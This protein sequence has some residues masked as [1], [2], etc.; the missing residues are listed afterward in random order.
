[1]ADAKQHGFGSGTQH[2]FL[3]IGFSSRF[4]ALKERQH[5]IILCPPTVPYPAIGVDVADRY[6]VGA[7]AAE[8]R[9]ARESIILRQHLSE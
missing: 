8:W 3:S 4:D 2:I 6:A 5:R 7:M 9:V 1:V